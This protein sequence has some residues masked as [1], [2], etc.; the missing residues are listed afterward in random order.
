MTSQNVNAK[1]SRKVA[2][3]VCVRYILHILDKN[4]KNKQSPHWGRDEEIPSSCPRFASST[5]RQA[6]SWIANLGQ[7]DG[8]LSSLPQYIVRFYFK[9]SN[10]KNFWCFFGL[11][12]FE[13][14]LSK[15][16]YIARFSVSIAI[17]MSHKI[18]TVI[19]MHH[20]DMLNDLFMP[21]D[22]MIRGI[23]FLSCLSVCLS[24]YCKL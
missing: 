23:L 24:V 14:N 9:I 4:E 8:I 1:Q 10:L 7:S 13:F 2:S 12:Q 17:A 6:S 15:F 5:T 20:S 21:P 19:V 16:D 18:K 11:F 3:S 22:Q